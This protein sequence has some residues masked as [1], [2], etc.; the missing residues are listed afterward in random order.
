M[1]TIQRDAVVN[2]PDSEEKLE[3]K[4]NSSTVSTSQ[5]PKFTDT[6][7]FTSY[8]LHN[9]E[10]HI[11]D[12]GVEKTFV[13]NCVSFGVTYF[14]YVYT[15]LYDEPVK[16]LK[17][18]LMEVVNEDVLDRFYR[19]LKT[20]MVEY[21]VRDTRFGSPNAMYDIVRYCHV[22]KSIGVLEYLYQH[23]TTTIETE[24][25]MQKIYSSISP[26]T[27]TQYEICDIYSFLCKWK[28]FRNY[29]TSHNRWCMRSL[30]RNEN[31]ILHRVFQI[32]YTRKTFLNIHCHLNEFTDVLF[33]EAT[34]P[35]L[36]WIKTIL[37]QNSFRKL[38]DWILGVRTQQPIASMKEHVLM[39]VF[40][41]LTTHGSKTLEYSISDY[42]D[43]FHGSVSIQDDPSETYMLYLRSKAFDV[44]V[45]PLFKKL[46]HVIEKHK[47]L[48]TTIE[49]A[50]LEYTTNEN[51]SLSS[52]SS[53]LTE[54]FRNKLSY[55][56]TSLDLKNIVIPI[57]L[58]IIHAHCYE[59]LTWLNNVHESVFFRTS[60]HHFLTTIH[61]ILYVMNFSKKVLQ[62][63]SLES[64]EDKKV[65][66][67]LCTTILEN[68]SIPIHYKTNILEYISEHNGIR[69]MSSDH[70]GKVWSYYAKL[71][72][73]GGYTDEIVDQQN[74]IVTLLR[75]YVQK[76]HHM[77]QDH[78]FVVD[79]PSSLVFGMINNLT[80]RMESYRDNY[81]YARNTYYS[82]RVLSMRE[83]I[84]QQKYSKLIQRDITKTL[85][86]LNIFIKASTFYS[87]RE[88]LLEKLNIEKLCETLLYILRYA[89]TRY[90]RTCPIAC[91][92]IQFTLYMVT[93]TTF[94]EAFVRICDT[95]E[96]KE[97][98]MLQ[99]VIQHAD[100]KRYITGINIDDSIQNILATLKHYEHCL[101]DYN[102]L[103]IPFDLLDPLMHTLIEN[104][105]VIPETNNTIMEKTVI[106]RYLKKKEENPFTRTKLSIEELKEY[107]ET[108]EAK[109][110]LYKFET[111]L[112]DFRKKHIKARS[113][114]TEKH[115]IRDD[116]ETES[117]NGGVEEES[118]VA[119]G[120]ESKVAE[121]KESK[122]VEDKE[123]KV[124]ED[125]ESRVEE[126]DEDN[127]VEGIESRVAEDTE[128]EVIEEDPRVGSDIST[129]VS[130]SDTDLSTDVEDFQS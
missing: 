116:T 4:E 29:L 93:F 120:K 108:N 73:I 1:S 62:Y 59:V 96:P 115:E 103:D 110:L 78:L 84:S 5:S 87:F 44:V 40:A 92:V 43:C 23:C 112:Q 25:L 121:G 3:S 64:V 45:H 22:N 18:E 57:V 81:E 119:E 66:L 70:V 124:V 7:T 15:T 72:K 117:K 53:S 51:A 6:D 12:N 77:E 31:S 38:D 65:A 99:N 130:D 88:T 102:S 26:E 14:M 118:K 68:E 94:G 16:A 20:Y 90:H 126:K 55:L 17:K 9:T 2:S 91:K 46:D 129:A 105:C 106:L 21:Y 127:V 76:K 13:E 79:D 83:I 58:D 50:T 48:D 10:E 128:C 125:K 28:R 86:L 54:M 32:A 11:R 122:A 85:E 24:K 19:F 49:V 107:N 69:L 52:V 8:L 104:P 111:K 114:K 82:D 33:Q 39:N 37:R 109:T 74:T 71:E 89:I 42:V 123:S 34:V 75:S 113:E 41:C 98:K 30:H 56:A 61:N 100:M 36:T 95:T 97:L 35:Y 101:I 80:T 67:S 27:L 60:Q 47:E 63:K